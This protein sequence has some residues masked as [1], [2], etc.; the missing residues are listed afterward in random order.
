MSNTLLDEI[1][2]TSQVT[3]RQLGSSLFLYAIKNSFILIFILM[4]I[5]D[6]ILLCL[7]MLFSFVFKL[8]LYYV[9]MKIIVSIFYGTLIISNA[10]HSSK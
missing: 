4:F 10:I 3:Y 8:I 6:N 2:K 5:P 1:D 9:F 7:N